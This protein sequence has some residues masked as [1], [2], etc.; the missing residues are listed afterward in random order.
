MGAGV[1][2]AL[3]RTHG[4]VAFAGRR[5]ALRGPRPGRG[6][7]CV[8]APR[9][10]GHLRGCGGRKCRLPRAQMASDR[11]RALENRRKGLFADPERGDVS[12]L[13]GRVPFDRSRGNA[14]LQLVSHPRSPVR[15]DRIHGKLRRA[16]GGRRNPI[17]RARGGLCVRGGG[18]SSRLRGAHAQSPRPGLRRPGAGTGGRGTRRFSKGGGKIPGL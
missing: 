18:R 11:A 15:A 4:T 7:R 17:H 1:R 8:S 9:A 2:R 6:K 13:C 10:G 16:A 3:H 14:R 12:G 5:C